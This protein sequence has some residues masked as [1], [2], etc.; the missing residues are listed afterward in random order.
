MSVES[1]DLGHVDAIA[2]SAF[3][4]W[5]AEVWLK[6]KASFHLRMSLKVRITMQLRVRV[7]AGCVPADALSVP[8]TSGCPDS[9]PDYNPAPT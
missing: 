8:Y 5:C 6:G 3:A 4:A 7:R 2:P 9:G 1:G